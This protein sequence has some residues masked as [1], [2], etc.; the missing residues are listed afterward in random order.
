MSRKESVEAAVDQANDVFAAMRRA[1]EEAVK[2]EE[3]HLD[4]LEITRKSGLEEFDEDVL[5]ELQLP[6]IIPCHRWLPWHYWWPWRPI[7]CWWWH[8]YHPW[9]GW[10]CPWW[11]HRCHWHH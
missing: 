2:G 3:T 8:R 9:Y 5:R 10:C 11:W 1:V 6:R 7:W 4:V